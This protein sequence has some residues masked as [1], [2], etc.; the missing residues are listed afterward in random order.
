[1]SEK[2]D[3]QTARSVIVFSTLLVVVF[4]LLLALLAV[5]LFGLELLFPQLVEVLFVQVGEDEVEHVRVPCYGVALDALFDVLGR[6]LALV[7]NN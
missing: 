3:F 5:A 1:V 6:M 2:G 4:A 7:T